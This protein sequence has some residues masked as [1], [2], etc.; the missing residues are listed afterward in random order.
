MFQ[1]DHI[2]KYMMCIYGLVTWKI[3]QTSI[4][5]FVVVVQNLTKFFYFNKYT[6]LL[7]LRS[8]KRTNFVIFVSIFIE[9]SEYFL[10]T[11]KYLFINT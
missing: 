11:R 9:E 7:T 2:L 5:I 10:L 3:L 6:S 4:Q 8:H 1:D